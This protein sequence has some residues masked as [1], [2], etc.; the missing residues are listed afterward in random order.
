MS[1]DLIQEYSQMFLLPSF[2]H[3]HWLVLSVYLSTSQQTYTCSKSTKE[4]LE[5]GA[6]YAR[7]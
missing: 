7:T 6:Q 1:K 2:D 3:Y 4:T 5:I